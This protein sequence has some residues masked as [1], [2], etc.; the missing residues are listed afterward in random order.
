LLDNAIKF[1]DSGQVT[2]DAKVQG[3]MVLIS[4]ND[5]GVGMSENR[6]ERLLA[7]LEGLQVNQSI[8][9]EDC[10][11]GLAVTKQLVDLHGGSFEFSSIVGQGSCFSFTLPLS[12]QA[13]SAEFD[14]RSQPLSRLNALPMEQWQELQ[15]I[16]S[17]SAHNSEQR[18]ILVVDHEPTSCRVLCAHVAVLKANVVVANSGEQAL[19]IIAQSG[20]FDLV[21]LDV[22]LPDINGFELCKRIRTQHSLNEL[23]VI[24]VT[25]KA[26]ISD[27]IEGLACGGNDFLSKPVTRFELLSR[28]K[29]QLR[30]VDLNRAAQAKL[31]QRNGQ[32]LQAN[33]GKSEFLAK[34]SHEIRVPMNAIIG[35]SRLTLKSGLDE[36]QSDAIEKVVDAGGVLLSLVNDTVDF[37]RIETGKLNIENVIVD[38]DILIARVVELCAMNAYIKGIEL[39]TDIDSNIPRLLRGDPLRLQQIIVNLVNNALKFT[40]TGA[41]CFKLDVKARLPGKILLHGCVI[42]TGV[43]MNELQQSQLSQSLTQTSSGETRKHG[44]TGLGLAIARQLCELMGGELWFNSE[45]EKGAV[46]HF[47]VM[48]DDTEA[49]IETSER[50]LSQLS[51]LK[52]MVVDDMPLAAN[53]SERLLREL[54]V[55]CTQVFNAEDALRLLLQSEE[56]QQH[57]DFVLIDWRMP[58]TD[59]IALARQLEQHGVNQVEKVLLVSAYDK[60]AASSATSGLGFCHLIEKPLLI[61]PLYTQLVKLCGGQVCFED[62]IKTPLNIPNLAGYHIL[63]VEGNAITRQVIRGFLADTGALVEQAENGMIGLAKLSVKPYDLVLIDTSMPQMNG[64]VATGEIRHT[65]QLPDLPVIAMLTRCHSDQSQ[66]VVDAGVNGFVTKP[67]EPQPLYLCLEKYLVSGGK[68]PINIDLGKARLPQFLQRDPVQVDQQ[69]KRQLAGL[70]KLRGIDSERALGKLKGRS[71]LYLTLVKDFMI[72]Y[73]QAEQ[74]MLHLFDKGLLDELF[75]HVHLLKANAIYIGAFKLSALCDAL[76]MAITQREVDRALF[77]QTHEVLMSLLNSL[78]PLFESKTIDAETQPYK[79]LLAN[80]VLPLLRSGNLKVKDQLP[81]LKTLSGDS[82]FITQVDLLIELVDDLEFSQAIEIAEKMLN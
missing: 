8:Y 48:L 7:Q 35:L 46:F 73:S 79:A 3:R 10:G 43:G 64:L 24:F 27:L 22:L 77:E 53:V 19:S 62:Y 9:F 80:V 72:E 39:V 12:G 58:Q 33:E 55:S 68:T 81:Q 25:V 13:V 65:L 5:Q 20:P 18:H 59:G 69:T 54:G 4:V 11:L 14:N 50:N 67:I 28:M 30:L 37:T 6:C 75:D 71:G 21:L 45:V 63:L 42:D 36:S 32:L 2:V 31:D 29:L 78:Q 66:S 40:E 70:S 52:V 38:L 17:L 16:D 23:A 61:N 56:D 76:E 51:E 15:Y 34:L 47:T 74:K 60:E 1:S 41:V 82:E 44:G 57:Y 26:H 49:V